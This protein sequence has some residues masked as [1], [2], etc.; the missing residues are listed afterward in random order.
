MKVAVYF[1][2][3]AFLANVYLIDLWTSL[4]ERFVQIMRIELMV[5]FLEDH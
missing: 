4:E 3:L 2:F 5:V 1:F